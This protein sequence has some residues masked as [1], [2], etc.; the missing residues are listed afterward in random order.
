MRRFLAA[1]SASSLLAG[2][3]TYY[4]PLY[5]PSSVANLGASAAAGSPALESC[6]GDEE[7][8][9]LT[10]ACAEVL[11]AIYS[12]S[13]RKTGKWEDIAQ[14][15]IIGAAGAAAWILLKGQDGYVKKVG[16]VGIGAG[17]Y[18]AGRNQLMPK[19]MPK[20]FIAGHAA[21]GCVIAEGP[22]FDA[23]GAN[24]TAE[25]LRDDLLW[26]ERLRVAVQAL[27]Y[28]EPPANAGVN[29]ELLKAA[30][31]IADQA[32]IQAEKQLE[33][34]QMQLAAYDFADSHFRKAVTDIGAWVASR[35]RVRPGL[36]YQG[37]FDGLKPKPPSGGTGKSIQI[38]ATSSD[39]TLRNELRIMSQSATPTPPADIV[40]TLAGA[41]AA[42]G[43][44]TLRLKGETPDYQGRL[45][46]V[47]KC[48][49][50]LPA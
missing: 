9:G 11:Q 14:L 42:L 30:R 23:D 24:N 48:A 10:L 40:S 5:S 46:V 6:E 39:P 12:D 31:Q 13:Y 43:N 47:K 34:S 36:S 7:G 41:A 33:A 45:N 27:R 21:L 50:D 15:P 49:T 28:V 20:Y 8:L 29:A 1:L 16:K 35:S 37:A 18:E 22:Y 2:C 32:V 17:V 44:A 26:V 25:T 4:P 38:L 3:S 19:D